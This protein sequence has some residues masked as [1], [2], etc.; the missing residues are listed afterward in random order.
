MKCE[1]KN[2]K[3]KETDWYNKLK[4]KSKGESTAEPL[5]CKLRLFEIM[6]K[7]RINNIDIKNNAE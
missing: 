2:F 1:I 3:G 5:Y 4:I 7:R 6:L